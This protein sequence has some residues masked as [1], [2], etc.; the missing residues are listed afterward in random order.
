MSVMLSAASAFRWVTQLTGSHDEAQLAQRVAQLSLSQRTG[1]PIFLPYLSGE[2]TPHNNPH[3]SGVFMGLHSAQTAAALGAARLAW[4]ADGGDV[5]LVCQ[6]L[7]TAQDFQPEAST[8]QLLSER[9]A[10]FRAL[11]PALMPL[12]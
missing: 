5:N 9:Y 8:T 11:Y 6:S 7:P 1:A 10:R 2:R 3:A 4:L 12:F